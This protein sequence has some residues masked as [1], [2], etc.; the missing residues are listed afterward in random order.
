MMGLEPLFGLLEGDIEGYPE[1][2]RD[3]NENMAQADLVNPSTLKS[4]MS[5]QL[6]I[7][8]S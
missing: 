7:K 5:V 3:E 4:L 1:L 8:V 6:G 2:Q